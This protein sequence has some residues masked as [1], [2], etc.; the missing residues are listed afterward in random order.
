MPRR[1]IEVDNGSLR[2]DCMHKNHTALSK[3]LKEREAGPLFRAEMTMERVYP[4]WS[5]EI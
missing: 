1:V 4:L 2:D 3:I 5:S